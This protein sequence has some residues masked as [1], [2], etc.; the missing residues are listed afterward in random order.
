MGGCSVVAEA[1]AVQQ[2]D[3]SLNGVIQDGCQGL[4]SLAVAAL[5]AQHAASSCASLQ[6]QPQA[7]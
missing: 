6:L 4:V 3:G 1:T 7:N 5:L 2:V